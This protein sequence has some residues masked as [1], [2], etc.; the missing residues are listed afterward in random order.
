MVKTRE[1]PPLGVF[2]IIIWDDVGDEII[3]MAPERLT[4]ELLAVVNIVLVVLLILTME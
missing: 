3:I 2:V 4:S 1:I